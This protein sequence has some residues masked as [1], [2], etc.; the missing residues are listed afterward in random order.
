MHLKKRL[1]LAVGV[2]LLAVATIVAASGEGDPLTR[3]TDR[4]LNAKAPVWSPDGKWIAFTGDTL[5]S[6]LMIDPRP[7]DA[8][9]MKSDGSDLRRLAQGH[10]YGRPAWSRDSQR[11]YFQGM[12][13]R[14]VRRTQAWDMESDKV[15]P[16][17][18]KEEVKRDELVSPDGTG[19]ILF[20][21]ASSMNAYTVSEFAIERQGGKVPIP[22]EATN[23]RFE[24]AVRGFQMFEKEPIDQANLQVRFNM[25]W[26]PVWSPDSS[27]IAF[28]H[29][30]AWDY[31]TAP[32]RT[33]QQ[34]VSCI[35]V[36]AV[37]D[38][39][40]I[41]LYADRRI[42]RYAPI[43][44]LGNSHV[45]FFLNDD[46]YKISVA[47]QQEP[48][49]IA[50]SI[51]GWQR[52]RRQTG[53]EIFPS[54]NG[55]YV[56]FSS[57]A[58]S[59]VRAS[60]DGSELKVL[61]TDVKSDQEWRP[62]WSSD[63]EWIAYSAGGDLWVMDH[64]G[65]Q[66][67]MIARTTAAEEPLS[68]SSDSKVLYFTSS[69]GAPSVECWDVVE[70]RACET[71]DEEIASLA[72][73]A[74]SPDGTRRVFT[75][76]VVGN[77][78][79]SLW[80]ERLDSGEKMQLASTEEQTNLRGAVWSPDSQWIAYSYE[81]W[82]GGSGK[83]YVHV[84]SVTAKEVLRL[85]EGWGPDWSPD[86]KQI[87]FSKDG[88]IYVYKWEYAPRKAH[89]IIQYEFQALELVKT[90]LTA[91]IQKC[92]EYEHRR[93]QERCFARVSN[94][95]SGITGQNLTR[96]PM[97]L[98]DVCLGEPNESEWLACLYGSAFRSLTGTDR[99]V[100]RFAAQVKSNEYRRKE[101]CDLFVYKPE[102]PGLSSYYGSV[103]RLRDEVCK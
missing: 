67:K 80:I 5:M 101:F 96:P 43:A 61:A 47:G 12:T 62:I 100:P 35:A 3:L 86:G 40:V 53:L 22:W 72:D 30:K 19:K 4:G 69:G 2:V 99:F 52:I 92:E 37:E 89:R 41:R 98:I 65:G 77:T 31:K 51:K 84:V 97:R 45:L 78:P 59:L 13:Q 49:K 60:A 93:D 10:Y 79:M 36:F 33:H 48:E 18:K 81:P 76:G 1:A 16:A 27:F 94:A 64:E 58:T 68:W 21:T 8:Y 70:G 63:S 32:N 56:L 14:S 54:P 103:G 17:A 74:V 26:G 42:P 9:V 85:S 57:D 102:N 38:Q 25:L 44:W 95:Y 91:A 15:T 39:K 29:N 88:H 50:S 34:D 20:K 75:E 66:K 73:A 28:G 23:L 55:K 6:G 11:V 24:D 46:L 7:S 87:A 71:T 90:D 82:S 83:M